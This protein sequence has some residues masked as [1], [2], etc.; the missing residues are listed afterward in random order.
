MQEV[1]EILWKA[2][3]VKLK[4]DKMELYDIQNVRLRRPLEGKFN[5]KE[6][7]SRE[8]KISEISVEGVIALPISF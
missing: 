3:S 6:I 8:Q 1:S 7:F 2:F 4:L 5:K